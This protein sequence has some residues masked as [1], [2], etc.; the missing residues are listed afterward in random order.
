[1]FCLSNQSWGS[2]WLTET[3]EK[4]STY[5]WLFYMR[6]I[7][8]N[9]FQRTDRQEN[10]LTIWPISS[11]VTNPTRKN[12]CDAKLKTNSLW[13]FSSLKHL[14]RFFPHLTT[15]HLQPVLWGVKN[16][17]VL[18]SWTSRISS[19]TRHQTLSP[20]LTRQARAQEILAFNRSAFK[21]NMF[22]EREPKYRS[23]GKL[24]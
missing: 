20:L 16:N 2:W 3:R 17:P 23:T 7:W 1:M 12:Y 9:Y 19:W 6:W 15:T 24:L 22:R 4:Y 13:H 14:D 8:V 5:Q 18:S 11:N 21:P 10:S